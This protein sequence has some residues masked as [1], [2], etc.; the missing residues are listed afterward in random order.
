MGQSTLPAEGKDLEDGR[1]LDHYKII[2]NSSTLHLVLCAARVGTEVE[3]RRVADDARVGEKIPLAAG[4]AAV[5]PGT[6]PVN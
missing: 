4:A 3:A 2:I 5:T 1:T 6:T